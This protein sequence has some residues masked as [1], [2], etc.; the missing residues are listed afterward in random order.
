MSKT[1]EQILKSLVV[2][3][4]NLKDINSAKEQ[5]NNVV[6][7]SGDLAKAIESYQSS[8]EKLSI[9]VKAI[10]DDSRK[11]NNDSVTK[12]AEQTI[13]FSKE[14]AKLTEFDVSKSLKAIENEVIK[15]FNLNLKEQLV[16]FD[17]KRLELQSTIDDFKAQILRIENVD[18]KSQVFDILTTMNNHFDE[19]L[20]ELNNN[21]EAV[22]SDSNK[23]ILRFDQQNKEIKLLKYSLFAICGLVVL[24]IILT[25]IK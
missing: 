21:I 23:I 4:Q 18:L 7:T 14:I 6:K 19:Q 9:N 15:Q 1:N 2:L 11:F 20:N 3:E 5:V 17:K 25:I 13:T 10:L 8:F 12:L 24:G 16:T 22:K